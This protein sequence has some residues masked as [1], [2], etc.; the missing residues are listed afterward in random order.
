MKNTVLFLV[1]MHGEKVQVK[2]LL[3]AGTIVFTG[4]WLVTVQAGCTAGSCFLG[5]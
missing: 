5:D 3:A 1:I 2:I 4:C